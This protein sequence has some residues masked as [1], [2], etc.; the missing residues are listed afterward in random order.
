MIYHEHLATYVSRTQQKPAYTTK[1]FILRK[2]KLPVFYLELKKPHTHILYMNITNSIYNYFE[3]KNTYIDLYL[4]PR[5]FFFNFFTK[6]FSFLENEYLCGA[7]MSTNTHL[8][9]I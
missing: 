5:L 9:Y 6:Y 4:E 7:C 1:K 2:L 8:T 3:K